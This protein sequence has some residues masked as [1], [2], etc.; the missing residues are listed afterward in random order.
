MG[1]TWQESYICPQTYVSGVVQ[2]DGGF[3]IALRKKGKISP[4]FAVGM[5]NDFLGVLKLVQD[6][7]GC[8]GIYKV[9]SNYSRLMVTDLKSLRE[10]DI[11][12]FNQYALW[13]DKNIYFLIFSRV[14]MTLL[15]PKKGMPRCE[16]IARKKAIV[17]LVH[18]MNAR[19]K[20][21]RR[22]ATLYM[23]K[24]IT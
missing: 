8:G 15:G 18:N 22:G 2:G 20:R 7:L 1:S 17:D 11:P 23:E 4:A 3:T 9:K 24:H 10:K 13:D 19:G 14:V 16:K 6:I 21:R 12:H 5:S